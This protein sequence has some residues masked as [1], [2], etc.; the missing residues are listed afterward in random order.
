MNDKTEKNPSLFLICV[1]LYLLFGLIYKY[2]DL[3]KG[4]LRWYHV[5]I[6]MPMGIVG[7]FMQIYP[8]DYI[9]VNLKRWG[10][11]ENKADTVAFILWIAFLILWYFIFIFNPSSD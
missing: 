5:V 6:L 3:L 8:Y 11:Y 10:M 9:K 2:S 1:G 7:L 4:P